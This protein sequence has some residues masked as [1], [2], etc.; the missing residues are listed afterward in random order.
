MPMSPEV[1]LLSVPL[2]RRAHQG[3]QQQLTQHSL[4]RN[5]E[6]N[7]DQIHEMAE[8]LNSIRA[9]PYLSPR[10]V[11][12]PPPQIS[13]ERRLWQPYHKAPQVPL[14]TRTLSV[15]PPRAYREP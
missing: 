10:A 7:H 6:G 12:D 1:V 14:R 3:Q 2:S 13:S 15:S 8:Y 11:E 9:C 5:N 4:D